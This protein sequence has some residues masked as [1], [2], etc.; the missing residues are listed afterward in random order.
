MSNKLGVLA[1][2]CAIQNKN[3]IFSELILIR[4]LIME[5]K[6]YCSDTT[7]KSYQL[8]LVKA[9]SFPLYGPHILWAFI[10]SIC[11]SYG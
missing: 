2:E 3:E 10:K 5:S 9:F 6:L 11:V 8:T 4:V 7:M 1:Y